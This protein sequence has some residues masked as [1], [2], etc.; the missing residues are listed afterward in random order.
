MEKINH[1]H[2]ETEGRAVQST[3]GTT[4][5]AAVDDAIQ[6]VGKA[7]MEENRRALAYHRFR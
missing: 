7:H 1:N 3:E 6:N 4:A 5:A 2:D